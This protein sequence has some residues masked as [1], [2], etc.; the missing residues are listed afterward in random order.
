MIVRRQIKMPNNI[1]PLEL[2][3][4]RPTRE[5]HLPTIHARNNPLLRSASGFVAD[6]L[7]EV[8]LILQ[9]HL[10]AAD[11][12]RLAAAGGVFGKSGIRIR[13]RN[14]G[15]RRWI[16]GRGKTDIRKRA[17]RLAVSRLA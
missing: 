9:H 2:H 5:I 17:D 7:F 6:A 16:F 4:H 15:R 1:L 8:G 3:I 11:L 12:D 13:D 10:L 14:A